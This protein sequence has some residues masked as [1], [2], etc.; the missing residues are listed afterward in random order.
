MA[1]TPA[2]GMEVPVGSVTAPVMLAKV[3]WAA[4][5]PAAGKQAAVATSKERNGCIET[6]LVIDLR[7]VYPTGGPIA[8]RSEF[9]RCAVRGQ[10]RNA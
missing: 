7:L 2:L 1:S 5:G 10:T 3:V 4:E 8:G 6:S 9:K